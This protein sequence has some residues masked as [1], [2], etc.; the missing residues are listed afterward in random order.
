M[1]LF[2]NRY[3][4]KNIFIEENQLNF[5]AMEKRWTVSKEKNGSNLSVPGN[6]F[7][8]VRKT[9]VIYWSR[10]YECF[11]IVVLLSRRH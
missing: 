2:T 8:S 1:R 6:N 4:N 3:R 10:A 9:S 5:G 11:I 7:V